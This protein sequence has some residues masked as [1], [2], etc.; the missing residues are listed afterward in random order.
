M[1]INARFCK[2]LLKL[3]RKDLTGREVEHFDQHAHAMR[4]D[5]STFLFEWYGADSRPGHRVFTT[6]VQADNV[7]DA[8]AQGINEWLTNHSVALR[9]V[10]WPPR[11]L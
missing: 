1:D 11:Q 4:I 8:K 10:D 6:E 7:A 3:A 5:R 9:A 2:I